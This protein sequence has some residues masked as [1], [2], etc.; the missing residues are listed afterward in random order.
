MG[1]RCHDARTGRFITADRHAAQG[2]VHALALDGLTD[3]EW[4]IDQAAMELLEKGM[5]MAREA[6]WRPPASMTVEEE[7]VTHGL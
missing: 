4:A 7:V 1:N 2:R 5:S 6:G 3:E